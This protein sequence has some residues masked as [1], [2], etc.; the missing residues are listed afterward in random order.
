VRNEG[1][2][3]F[4]GWAFMPAD[5]F[6]D[7]D[8]V[9]VRIEA[10]GMRRKDFHVELHDDVL[11]VWGEKQ[12]DGKAS[13]GRYSVVQCAYGS[14]RRDVTLPVP[15]KLRRPAIATACCASS[16]PKPMRHAPGA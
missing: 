6:G 1:W 15:V 2:L 12:F 13:P 14:F 10:P 7:D 9:I 16:F 11:T 5:M 8:K 3:P 4:G